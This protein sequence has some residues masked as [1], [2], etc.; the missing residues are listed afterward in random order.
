MLAF[1]VHLRRRG[2]WTGP[3]P[4]PRAWA[5]LRDKLVRGICLDA[6]RLLLS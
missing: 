4:R 5:C 3:A 1:S 2:D 6:L